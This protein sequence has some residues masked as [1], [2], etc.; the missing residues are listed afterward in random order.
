MDG[1]VSG[2]GHVACTLNAVTKL[3]VPYNA[4]KFLDYLRTG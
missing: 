2:Y 1:A 4:R 3:H